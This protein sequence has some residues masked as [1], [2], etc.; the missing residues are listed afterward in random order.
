MKT[1]FAQW[2]RLTESIDLSNVDALIIN[3]SCV[4]GMDYI[5]EIE[6]QFGI[7]VLQGDQVSLWSALRAVND[8]TNIPELG[9]IFEV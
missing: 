4:Q 9:R 1:V 6:K 8:Q 5:R 7:Q 3:A 2:N